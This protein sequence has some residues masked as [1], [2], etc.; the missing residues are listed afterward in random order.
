LIIGKYK[1]GF[2]RRLG[3]SAAFEQPAFDKKTI[4]ALARRAHS[5]RPSASRVFG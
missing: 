5:P 2:D 1:S 3:L 4:G